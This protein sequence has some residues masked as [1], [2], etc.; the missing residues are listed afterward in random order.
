MLILM[1]RV[2]GVPVSEAWPNLFYARERDYSTRDR[3]VS[4]ATPQALG[5]HPIYANFLFMG[6]KSRLHHC[7]LASDGALWADM[8]H[9]L[10]D[11]VPEAAR[12]RPRQRM[13]TAAREFWL[14]YYYLCRDPTHERA[15]KFLEETVSETV[16]T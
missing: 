2:P 16:E 6:D 8:E 11:T 10:K 4:A 15:K 3:G 9:G 12:R 14:D 7:P 1:K 13:P 5:G